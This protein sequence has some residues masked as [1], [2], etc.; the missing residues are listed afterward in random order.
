MATAQPQPGEAQN[1][2]PE[3]LDATELHDYENAARSRPSSSR[4][5]AIDADAN[6]GHIGR[7]Q[8]QP[9][10]T[11]NMI[12]KFWRRHVVVT[13]SHSACRDHFGMYH[14]ND[15]KLLTS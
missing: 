15:N 8:R 4:A 1:D 3:E 9:T 14:V 11:A 5:T 7:R 6:D 10:S 12:R 13:V 2:D